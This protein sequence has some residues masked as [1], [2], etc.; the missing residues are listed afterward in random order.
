VV[1]KAELEAIKRKLAKQSADEARPATDW[2]KLARKSNKGLR[3]SSAQKRKRD[4]LG[5]RLPGSGW[6]K[7]R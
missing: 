2:A 4:A 3:K 5:K 7:S 6:T 1:T